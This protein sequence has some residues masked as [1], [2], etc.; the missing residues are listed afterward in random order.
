MD[1]FVSCVHK[2]NKNRFFTGHKNG[3]IFE[4]KINYNI[5]KK[6]EEIKSI[7]I[8]RDLIAHKDSMVCCINYIKK[9]NILL[10]SSND[11]NLFIRKYFD[12][13]LLSIIQ[14]RE[15]INRFVYTDYDLLYLLISPKGTN[16]NK[17]YINIY[18]LNGLLLETS[19]LDYYVDI[20]PM[21]NGKIFCNIANSCKLGIFGFNENIQ[22]NKKSKILNN[23]SPHDIFGITIPKGNIEEYDII[24]NVNKEKDSNK[25]DK[26]QNDNF[27]NK[28][29]SDFYLKQKNNIF[30]IYLE[31]KYLVRQMIFDFNS[32]YKGIQKLKFIDIDNK[33]RKISTNSYSSDMVK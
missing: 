29:I 7:E 10:T 2:I 27:S 19:E 8:I 17:S 16:H 21:K 33:D 6:N 28:I 24:A 30:Y 12:F 4:F 11:G 3:K 31:N 13:E 5:D 18:T 26:K 20:E 23:D 25:K 15:N 1:S 32:L 14:T 22:Q 9:H